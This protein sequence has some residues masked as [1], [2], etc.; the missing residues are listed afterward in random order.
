MARE[1]KENSTPANNNE[2]FSVEKI[3]IDLGICGDIFSE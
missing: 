2:G 1:R 3:V